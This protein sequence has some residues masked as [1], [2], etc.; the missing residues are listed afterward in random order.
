M[1]MALGSTPMRLRGMLL[2]QGLLVVAAVSIWAG[3]R[4]LREIDVVLTLRGSWI[5]EKCFRPMY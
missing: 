3:T 1:R 5:S 4:R 2:R